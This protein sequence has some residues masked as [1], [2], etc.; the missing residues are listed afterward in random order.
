M[1]AI[2]RTQPFRGARTP[3]NSQSP[4]IAVESTS[5]LSLGC[6]P[7]SSRTGTD[8]STTVLREHAEP[9][10]FH[11]DDVAGLHRARARRCARQD[12]VARLERDRAGDVGD[13]VPHVPDHLVGVPA[14]RDRAV[15][16]RLDVLAVEV[17]VGHDARPERAQG[18]GPLHAQHRPGVGVAEVVQ[19]VVV[20]DRVARDV[21]VGL[22][23]RDVAASL[24]R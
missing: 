1:V 16:A 19:P 3:R 10:D 4:P 20:A 8:P 13:Q 12:H 22:V 21:G 15:H 14:L 6:A 18:V 17:P 24:A 23:G 9:F 2:D 5:S 7:T 11:F